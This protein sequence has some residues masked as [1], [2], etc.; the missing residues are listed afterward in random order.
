MVIDLKVETVIINAEE[1]EKI[2]PSSPS[3]SRSFARTCRSPLWDGFILVLKTIG[4][5]LFAFLTPWGGSVATADSW[6]CYQVSVCM[7]GWIIINHNRC[8]SRCKI[9]TFHLSLPSPYF[10]RSPLASSGASFLPRP[11][12]P[13]SRL[14]SIVSFFRVPTGP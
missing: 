6:S 14:S 4:T 9:W 5:H 11:S 7:K 13:L 3:L 1:G 8:L 12:F 10:S 2:Q